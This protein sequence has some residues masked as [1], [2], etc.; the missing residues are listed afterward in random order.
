MNKPGFEVDAMAR[1]IQQDHFELAAYNALAP[2]G[3][4]FNCR[5]LY[6]R[7]PKPSEDDFLV[8]N[9]GRRLFLFQ[10]AEGNTY[11]YPR[12]RAL[13]AQQKVIQFLYTTVSILMFAVYTSQPFCSRPRQIFP[14]QAPHPILF[15]LVVGTI[16]RRKPALPH[17]AYQADPRVLY[18]SHGCQD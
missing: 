6:H 1:Q 17:F 3:T 14:Q 5:P 8:P 11:D 16:H 13:T 12:W 7:D 10:K 4:P 18:Q 2:L 15:R 9:Q